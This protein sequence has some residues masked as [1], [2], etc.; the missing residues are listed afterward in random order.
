MWVLYTK[1]NHISTS[2]SFADDFIRNLKTASSKK[3]KLAG[4]PRRMKT[5]RFNKHIMR[6]NDI[7]EKSLHDDFPDF[8]PELKTSQN[9]EE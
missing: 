2:L 5:R 9:D 6:S 7:E 4:R 1:A 8:V 3:H